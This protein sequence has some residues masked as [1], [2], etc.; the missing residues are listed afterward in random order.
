MGLALFS[1]GHLTHGHPV[2]FSGKYFKPVQYSVEESGWIDYEKLG[3]LVLLEKPKLLIAGTTSYPRILDFKKFRKIADSVGAYLLADISHIA[4]L[5]IAGVHP[6]PVGL[7]DVIM[8]TTHKTLRGPR[9]AILMTDN[10][11]IAQKID[12]AVFPGLQGG[13]HE[14]TIAAVAVALAEATRP[15]FKAYGQ[16]IVKNAKVLAQT[17]I[18]NSIDLV[19]GGTDNH[20]MVIDLRKLNLTGKEVAEKLE[21][22]GIITNKNSVPNDPQPPAITSGIRI[23]TPAVTTRGMKEKEMKRIGEWVSGLILEKLETEKVRKEVKELCKRFPTS[24]SF[25][26]ERSE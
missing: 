5:I 3:R 13:P 19:T 21:S 17:L 9:G 4:G 22:A 11:E 18:N 2:T 23:G 25:W 16:Q 10:L 1:G 24:L 6:S 14:N 26:N 8:T 7:A 15:E 20:L 12:R